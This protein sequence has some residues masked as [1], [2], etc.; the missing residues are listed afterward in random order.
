M[1]NFVDCAVF[2]PG[3][4]VA[5]KQAL[6]Q[7]MGIPVDALVIGCVAAVKKHH[8][9]IDY[10]IRE[11]ARLSDDANR[12]ETEEIEQ[13]EREERKGLGFAA[14]GGKEKFSLFPPFPS[15]Q[16][17]HLLI[18][19]A[20]TGET[21]ELIAL[22]ES[23]IP[24][25]YKILTDCGRDRMPGLYHVMDV[26]VLTSLFEMMPIAIL[27]GLASG[28][29]V[30]TNN[31]PVMT[32]MTGAE[33]TSP[34]R[35]GDTEKKMQCGVYSAHGNTVAKINATLLEGRVE[36]PSTTLRAGEEQSGSANKDSPLSLFPLQEGL[37]EFKAEYSPPSIP[38]TFDSLL[39][40]SV[41]L[42]QRVVNSS[43]SPCG[44]LAIDMSKEG[45]LA[46]ALAGLT[47]E[48][49]AEHGRQARERAL[50]MFSKEAVIGQYVE[51]YRQVLEGE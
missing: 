43:S 11:F 38:A 49:I 41:P 40:V 28:L 13:K 48:W 32:W 4:S 14:G 50:R 18:A 30:I 44:G 16:T 39:G 35:L 5:E 46:E 6:R 8:K 20:G 31:H 21:A 33:N 9:R 37:R 17:P 45:A 42:A 19:G 23:L 27:E 26:F 24:G 34:Q 12:W 25:R 7:A 22:A 47:P 29:P 3:A 36:S 10:L 1:P 2:R 51:Y 15:V